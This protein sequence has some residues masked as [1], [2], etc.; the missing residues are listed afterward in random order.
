MSDCMRG[1]VNVEGN[2]GL[3]GFID[4]REF[5]TPA[6]SS[7]L[8]AATPGMRLRSACTPSKSTPVSVEVEAPPSSVTVPV[9]HKDD[10]V[11]AT[12]SRVDAA[13]SAVELAKNAGAFIFCICNVVGSL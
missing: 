12:S 11:I 1:R 5:S 7:S 6:V 4:N 3:T 10:I 13:A 9:I 8:H 2:N